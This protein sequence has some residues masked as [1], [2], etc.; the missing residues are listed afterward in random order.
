MSQISTLTVDDE[1]ADEHV[2][3]ELAL[4]NFSGPFDLLL[5]LI[6]RRRMDVTE[7]ALAEVTDEFLSYVT[8]LETS[9]EVLENSSSFMEIGR[10][11]V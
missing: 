4:T 9:E 8:T 2:G 7:V 3:F 10:A 5:S 1:Y 6:A 11:H